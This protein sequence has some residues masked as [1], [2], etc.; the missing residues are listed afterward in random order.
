MSKLETKTVELFSTD[1]TLKYKISGSAHDESVLRTIELN[2]I[3]EPHVYSILKEIIQP[4]DVCVDLGANIG[5]TAIYM[6]SLLGNSGVVYAFEPSGINFNYLKENIKQNNL[7]NVQPLELG[8][9]DKKCD[10]KFSYVDGV[11]ACSFISTTG[12]AEGDSETVHCIRIDDWVKDA[13][14]RKIDIVKLDVEGCEARAIKGGM[15]MFRKFKPDLVV[16]FNPTTITRFQGEDP[17]ILFDL[18]SSI[19]PKIYMLDKQV[20]GKKTEVKSYDELISYKVSELDFYDLY[21]TFP[22]GGFL[23]KILS[24]VKR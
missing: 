14:I 13:N 19:Y 5:V 23:Q 3:Y 24:F 20:P 18:I 16:E 8:V 10:S 15:E 22:K 1:R 6:S 11:A 17:R 12:V 21:C 4:G 7:T 2:Q 9:F